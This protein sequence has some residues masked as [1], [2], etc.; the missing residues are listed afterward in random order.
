MTIRIG[1]GKITGEIMFGM[2]IV[3]VVMVY[4]LLFHSFI[5]WYN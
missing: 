3:E 2:V 5:C 1:M 4:C